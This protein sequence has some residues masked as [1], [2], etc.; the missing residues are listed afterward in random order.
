MTIHE[1]RAAPRPRRKPDLSGR[2]GYPN[3]RRPDGLCGRV[4]VA[5]YINQHGPGIAWRCTAHD[6]GVVVEVAAR[7][8]YIRQPVGDL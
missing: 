1:W 6:K 7:M 8:G 4:P 5:G 2:C 3:G